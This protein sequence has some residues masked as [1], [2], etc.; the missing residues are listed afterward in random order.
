MVTRARRGF[1]LIE[2]M[3]V[4]VI[5]M[6]LAAVSVGTF[7][8]ATNETSASALK[9]SLQAMADAELAVATRTGAYSA[10]P[11]VLGELRNV[12]FTTGVATDA[13]Q[14]S[15]ALGADGSAGFAASDGDG[16]CAWL[17][18]AAPVR[19]A[20]ATMV[21]ADPETTVCHGQA[22]LAEGVAQLD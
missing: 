10:D 21:T 3:A 14:V 12:T 2:L 22:A 4:L 11:A 9:S 8:A 19:G 15:V 18:L 20:V 17:R 5:T 7:R 6:S 13:R 16:G 1:S